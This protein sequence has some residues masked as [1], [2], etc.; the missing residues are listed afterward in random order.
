MV[1][2]AKDKGLTYEAPRA[3]RVGDQATGAGYCDPNGSGDLDGCGN[4]GN[5]A[6]GKGCGDPGNN[7]GGHG[8][9]SPGNSATGDG[10]DH[11]GNSPVY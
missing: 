7:A 4:T 2:E 1:E 6:A 10:C 5:S 9:Y 8:C 3:M 11:T